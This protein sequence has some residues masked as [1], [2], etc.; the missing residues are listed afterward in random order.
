MTASS[1][2][3]INRL[4][5]RGAAL[6]RSPP[7]GDGRKALP[8]FQSCGPVDDPLRNDGQPP[9]R[10]GSGGKVVLRVGYDPRFE[11]CKK[12]FEAR[13]SLTL[14]FEKEKRGRRC[15]REVRKLTDRISTVDVSHTYPVTR[16]KPG[17]ECECNLRRSRV[18]PRDTVGSAQ[19]ESLILA[20]NERWRQA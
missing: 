16:C 13:C 9:L 19:L 20:Q 17:N 1:G 3:H 10:S 8:I 6:R 2:G 4:H 18:F 5:R 12:R 14:W 11:A 15:P 7:G